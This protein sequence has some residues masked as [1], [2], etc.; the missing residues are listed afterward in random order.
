MDG[1][2]PWDLTPM[3]PIAATGPIS[4]YQR[5]VAAFYADPRNRSALPLIV[6]VGMLLTAVFMVW[7]W[8]RVRIDSRGARASR[9]F[10][11]ALALTILFFALGCADAWPGRVD[12]RFA[13][14]P[15]FADFIRGWLTLEARSGPAGVRVA[16][17][18]TNIPY[19]LFGMGLRNDVRYVNIDRHR[20]WLMHDYHRQAASAGKG[21]WPNSRPGWDRIEP[22]Y[23]AWVDNLDAAGIQ[24]IVVTRVNPDEGPH[25]VADA[26]YFPVERQWANAHPERFEVIYGSRENDPWFRLYRFRRSH[27]KIQP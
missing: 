27:G 1:P 17:S 2:I 16:Y 3:I 22:D 19:Y 5:V 11:L 10:G 6:L 25:N 24:Y 18:G 9:R 26:D 7:T 12:P 8:N 14:Y 4:L 20:D 23:Q 15:V 21:R 13:F